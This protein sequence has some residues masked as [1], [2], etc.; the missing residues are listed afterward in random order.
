MTP[1]SFQP[2]DAKT[3]RTEAVVEQNGKRFRV[4]KGAVRTDRRDLRARTAGN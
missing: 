2:F 4:M 3:R 1:I